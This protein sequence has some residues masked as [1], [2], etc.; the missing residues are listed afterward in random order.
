MYEKGTWNVSKVIS[1]GLAA[2]IVAAGALALDQGHI[3]A[4]PRGIVEIGELVPVVDEVRLAIDAGK[5]QA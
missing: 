5:S 1:A 4:A 2:A 3:A